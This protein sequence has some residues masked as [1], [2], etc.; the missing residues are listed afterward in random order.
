MKRELSVHRTREKSL[1]SLKGLEIKMIAYPALKRWANLFRA[2]GT[3]VC[4]QPAS[5]ATPKSDL[6]HFK[7]C[8]YTKLIAYLNDAA[9]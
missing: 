5:M 1:A 4:A 9:I 7:R 8:V 2:Y 3:G 6:Q